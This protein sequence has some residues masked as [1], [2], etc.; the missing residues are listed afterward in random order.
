MD[1]CKS[2]LSTCYLELTAIC[3]EDQIWPTIS[4]S[5][6]TILTTLETLFLLISYFS[7]S[8]YDVDSELDPDRVTVYGTSMQNISIKG[9]FI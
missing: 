7:L 6:K 3:A 2:S 1:T 4:A 5:N 9:H 8:A